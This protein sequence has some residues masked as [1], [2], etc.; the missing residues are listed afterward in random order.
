MGMSCPSALHLWYCL[1]VCH[2]L[3]PTRDAI[4]R[5]QFQN[6][7]LPLVPVSL[8]M[9]PAPWLLLCDE[10]CNEGSVGGHGIGPTQKAEEGRPCEQRLPLTPCPSQAE[11]E[12][13]YWG[14]KNVSSAFC[15]HA[16]EFAFVKATLTYLPASGPLSPLLLCRSSSQLTDWP[17]AWLLG[18]PGFTRV[19]LVQSVTQAPTQGSML[20][21][22]AAVL[23]FLILSG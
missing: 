9:L 8:F 7:I 16:T 13:Y 2:H 19:W 15:H 14:F 6:D 3:L 22:A 17:P 23:K 4:L 18:R 5:R 12:A 20:A 10:Q 21:S 11:R 1:C